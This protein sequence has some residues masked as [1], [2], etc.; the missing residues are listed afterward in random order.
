MANEQNLRPLNERT[1][2]E[3]RAIQ[4]KGGKASG[5]ARRER[6]RM[7]ELARMIL[8]EE[9]EDSNGRTLTRGEAALRMQARRAVFD[10][11]LKA[12]A[13]LRD[14]AGEAPVSQVE[15]ATADQARF[16]ELLDQ[17]EGG[18]R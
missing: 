1:K 7:Q 10:G 16:T 6:K 4:S 15:V 9:I 13:F 12:L 14:T 2:S 17:L 5:E 18:E 3:Q 11:D 8:D